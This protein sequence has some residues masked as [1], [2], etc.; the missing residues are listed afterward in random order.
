[1]IMQVPPLHCE[2]GPQL[3]QAA[4]P[5][6][7]ANA[8]FPGR[9]LPLR[10][11]PIGQVVASQTGVTHAPLRH[12][13]PCMHGAHIAPPVPQA[14][15]TCIDGTTQ[16]PPGPQQPAQVPRPHIA[17]VQMPLTHCSPSAQR[18]HTPPV[19][20][21]ASG[22]SPGA[23][24][25]FWVQ[26]HTPASAWPPALPPPLPAV[27]PPAPPAP[28]ASAMPPPAAGEPPP[29]LDAPPPVP[30]S[31]P[32]SGTTLRHPAR[33]RNTRARMTGPAYSK[34]VLLG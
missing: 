12:C 20:P 33:Q 15:W 9:Q 2:L 29:A 10:Q 30:P 4:P 13:W 25:P 23:Q 26:P 1:M 5:W 11:Q 16:N 7:Q 22:E 19:L 3:V 8:E 18:L 6:P 21:Q 28:P 31:G 17:T 24:R 27:P 32:P 34:A 14:N